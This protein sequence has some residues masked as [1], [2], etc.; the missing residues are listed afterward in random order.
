MTEPNT[1]IICV[2]GRSRDGS[3]TKFFRRSSGINLSGYKFIRTVYSQDPQGF[4][5]DEYVHAEDYDTYLKMYQE[6]GIL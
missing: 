3:V 1:E 6:A 2:K 4:S 5:F